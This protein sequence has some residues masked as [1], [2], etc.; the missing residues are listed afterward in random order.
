[1][2]QNNKIF[3]AASLANGASFSMILPLLAPLVRKLQLSELQAGA[4]VSIGALLMACA[5]IYISKNQTKFSIYQLLS[6][7][8]IGMAVTWGLFSGVLMYG[9][10]AQISVMLLFTLLMLAR[11]STGVFMAMPQIALQTHVMT[12]YEEEQ[13]RS[14]TMSKFGAL[15]SVGVVFGP[16][17]TTLLLAWGMMTPLWA[18]IA[19]LSIISVVIVV[20]FDQQKPKDAS[21]ENSISL[22]STSTLAQQS[23]SLDSDEVLTEGKN[24]SLKRSMAWLVLGFSLYLAIVTVNLTAGFYIQ[25]HFK[26]SVLQGATYFS[27]CSLLVGISLVVMQ[28]LIS[29]K[30]KW[31]VYT[32]LWVGLVAMSIA[33]WISVSTEH[34]RVFQLA[35]VLYGVSVAC[36]I[37]AFTTGAAQ[38]APK[39]QQAKVASWCTATQALSFVIGPILSTGLYQWHT[40]YPYYFLMLTMFAL[41]VFFAFKQISPEKT[42]EL[43]R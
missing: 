25:D 3:I 13:L 31:S 20:L 2:K 38:T 28:V 18:A 14:K 16:F 40:S 6:I 42:A 15:N 29:K 41:M 19:I 22:E 34:L 1:M 33:L 39:H 11:A 23:K 10:T 36:L 9:L 7:G 37:P 17:L 24:F 21:S 5:A 43:A 8:F 30:L 32:L 27:Q 12:S 35:Y 4:M 26:T